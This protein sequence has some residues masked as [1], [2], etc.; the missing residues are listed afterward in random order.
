MQIFAQT[1]ASC[2]LSQRIGSPHST[3]P[4][5]HAERPILTVP[6]ENPVRL[7]ADVIPQ[8][9][10]RSSSSLP[11]CSSLMN[12]TRGCTR[13]QRSVVRRQISKAEQRRP[14]AIDSGSFRRPGVRSGGAVRRPAGRPRLAPLPVAEWVVTRASPS[15]A[16]DAFSTDDS[17]RNMKSGFDGA[18][19]HRARLNDR[20]TR[21][22]SNQSP[23]PHTLAAKGIAA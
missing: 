23:A 3:V 12:E 2:G 8:G 19:F 21:A 20:G 14:S 16:R 9:Q 1:R 13:V 22:E 4:Q 11:T 15:L 10:P 18:R 17:S 7:V 5:S 6:N